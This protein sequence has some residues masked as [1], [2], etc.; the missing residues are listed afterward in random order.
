MTKGKYVQSIGLRGYSDKGG[1]GVA[2]ILFHP[3]ELKVAIALWKALEH[4]EM[5]EM[6][7]DG[8][9]YIESI[10]NLVWRWKQARDWT[11][12]MGM[13]IP[14]D[15][16]RSPITG[17]LDTIRYLE[18]YGT[19]TDALTGIQF[20]VDG[21]IH[22]TEPE[23]FDFALLGEI[24]KYYAKGQDSYFELENISPHV[25]VAIEQL[26]IETFELEKDGETTN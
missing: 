9:G 20:N 5:F 10:E 12:T 21:C 6:Y 14:V 11:F 26:L 13:E 18:V 4:K 25:S 24:E 7:D 17:M 22:R 19:V 8:E 1:P 15:G 16:D 3:K 2:Y 23:Y